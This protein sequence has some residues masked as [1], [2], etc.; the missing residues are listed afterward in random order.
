ML[1]ISFR[2]NHMPQ[3]VDTV[4]EASKKGVRWLHALAE[5]NLSAKRAW[6]MCFP[7]LREAVKKVGRDIND[8]PQ[9]IPGRPSPTPQ[10]ASMLNGFGD[11]NFQYSSNMYNSAPTLPTPGAGNPGSMYSGTMAEIPTSQAFSLFDPMMHYD[12]YFPTDFQMNDSMQYQPADAEMDQFINSTYH[13]DNQ[14]QGPYPGP[15]GGTS[16][17]G[18]PYN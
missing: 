17:H 9:D 14:G 8:M 18:P 16:Q 15:Q 5:D 6:I 10:H 4:L 7:L 12:Q 3:E 13:P 11:A 2:A 1:E